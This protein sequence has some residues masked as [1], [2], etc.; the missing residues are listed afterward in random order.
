MIDS[1]LPR[2]RD[3]TDLAMLGTSAACFVVTWPKALATLT[4]TEVATHQRTLP[5]L[6]WNSSA[7]E[8]GE[9]RR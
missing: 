9:R 7:E 8:A 1:L 5:F 6:S 3:A 4:L 2:F